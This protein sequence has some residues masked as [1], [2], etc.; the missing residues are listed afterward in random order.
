M[1]DEKA[2]L[3]LD[4]K[5]HRTSMMRRRRRQALL[6]EYKD[7]RMAKRL[8]GEKANGFTE[9]KPSWQ[10]SCSNGLD[11]ERNSGR[12]EHPS[13]RRGKYSKETR[14]N[15]L[16]M[17]SKGLESLIDLAEVSALSRREI[18]WINAVHM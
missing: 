2:Q 18:T 15:I 9:R 10:T 8:V 5:F 13:P 11:T 7:S 6:E 3:Y 4:R 17:A 16:E 1:G 14:V 12:E